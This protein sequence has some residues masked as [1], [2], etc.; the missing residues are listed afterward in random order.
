MATGHGRSRL[1][2]QRIIEMGEYL[3]ID[4]IKFVFRAST[5]GCPVLVEQL[6]QG[7]PFPGQDG[8]KGAGD[9]R[10]Q[11]SIGASSFAGLR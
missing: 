5:G 9:T 4:T 1:T 6:E 11:A 8:G 3:I 7:H 10:W 2:A